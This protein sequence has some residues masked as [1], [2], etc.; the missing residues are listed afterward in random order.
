MGTT[1]YKYKWGGGTA[2]GTRN[3]L[4]TENSELVRE[5]SPNRTATKR[6]NRGKKRARGKRFLKCITTNAQSLKNKMEEFMKLVEIHKP[7]VISVTESWGKEW[8][9][10][11]IFSLKG[12]SMYRDDRQEKEGGGTILYISN[13]LE[14]R[15]CRP[16]NTN[17][18]E[19][20]TWCWI[21]E[22]G[23]RKYLLGVYIGVHLVQNKI[24]DVY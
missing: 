17:N 12:Y 21:I 4:E 16:L 8:I 15:G 11:G 22:K 13:K 19:S 9:N 20:S 6:K 24:T 18:F 23:V 14:H 1:W 10:D 7:Q 3:I 5:I 2:P